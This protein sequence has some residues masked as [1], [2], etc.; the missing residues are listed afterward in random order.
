MMLLA[1]S[2]FASFNLDR[3]PFARA[4]SQ[5]IN[6]AIALDGVLVGD[7]EAPVVKHVGCPVEPR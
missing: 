7:F 1:M 6:G 3:D 4:L 2:D 5:H